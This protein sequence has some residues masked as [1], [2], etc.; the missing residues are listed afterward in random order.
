MDI[1]SDVSGYRIY[2]LLRF[3]YL[4][5]YYRYMLPFYFLW[6]ANYNISISILLEFKV[7]NYIYGKK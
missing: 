3:S 4:C 7:E 2:L 1:N 6:L 5:I